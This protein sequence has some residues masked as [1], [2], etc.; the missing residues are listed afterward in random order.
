MGVG[1]KLQDIRRNLALLE[2]QGKIKGFFRNAENADELSGL[3]EDIRDTMI[4]YQVCVLDAPFLSAW[5]ISL[6]D[7][8]A[9]RY[10][11]QELP[12]HRESHF[13]TFRPR[14]LTDG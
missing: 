2:E 8:F 13:I 4:D 9:T 12:T 14:R 11:R 10:V 7:I 6:L 1:R 3:V 5:L